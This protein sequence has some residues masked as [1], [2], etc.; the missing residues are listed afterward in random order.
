MLLA[1]KVMLWFPS[2][3]LSSAALLPQWFPVLLLRLVFY[4]Y[5]FLVFLLLFLLITYCFILVT[6]WVLPACFTFVFWFLILLILFI[7]FAMLGVKGHAV[8]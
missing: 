8:P 2:L 4:A 3:S 5:V 1:S 6:N 7:Q